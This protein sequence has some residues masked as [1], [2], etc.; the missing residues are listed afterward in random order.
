MASV[1]S[2]SPSAQ[3]HRRT[4]SNEDSDSWQ[5]IGSN[6]G[7]NPASVFSPSP[8][9]GAG[10]M[11][12]WVIPRYPNHVER[13]P[14]GMSPLDL[15]TESQTA[16]S[17]SFPDQTAT[18]LKPNAGGLNT[19]FIGSV[20]GGTE[21]FA[22]DPDF[23]FQEPF[24]NTFDLSEYYNP[25]DDFDASSITGLE[26]FDIPTQ[27]AD[28]SVPAHYRSSED[29]ALPWNAANLRKDEQ[30]FEFIS[31]DA[32]QHS[33]SNSGR[34]SSSPVSPGIKFEKAP[35]P[36]RKIQ[37]KNNKIEKKKAEPASRFVI[38]TPTIINASAGKPNPYEC[39][40]AMRP[41]HKGRKG[42]LANET[43]ESALQCDTQRP[44]KN[45]TK[46]TAAV[47]Q[48]MCWQFQ[49]FLPVLFPDFIR[50]H[51][52]KDQM[53]SFFSQHIE[54]FTIG[55]VEQSCE[56]ELF[57]G[58]RFDSTLTVRANF[59][60]AKTNEVLQ[61]WHM[62]IGMNQ[63]DLQTRD[64]APIGIDLDNAPYR[65]DLRKKTRDYIQRITLEP[66]FA[67]QVTDSFRHT[68]LPCKV[69]KIVQRFSQRSDSSMVKKA[70]SIYAMHYVLTR[71]LCM[72][73]ASIH[74]LQGTNLIPR[75]VPWLT[76]RVL[77]RQVKSILDEQLL[78]EM[79]SLFDGFSKSLKPKSRKEWAPCLAAFL[80]LCLFMEAL[81]TAA[82][83][84]VAS[85]NEIN[86]RNQAK[87]G[88][89]QDFA[90]QIC[91]E[92]ENM[93]FKQFAYQFHQVYQTHTKDAATKAFN[94]LL[95]GSFAEQGEL[96]GPTHEMVLALRKLLQGDSYYELDFLVADPIL[97]NEGTHP[98]PR[99]VSLNYTGRLLARFLLSFEDDR[100]LFD[101]RY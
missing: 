21:Q 43:K 11:N 82:D 95:D 45:C 57:S 75:N 79:Q 84:F 99:D 37:G 66:Q 22:P 13:S 34:L 35:S 76:P 74:S 55:G 88:Y 19:Q 80:V 56:V 73:P 54:S 27:T 25:F 3:S 89:K 97:P 17:T 85:Q 44:C 4:E 46:L 67:E 30:A 81:E 36:L 6:V 93:P 41:S 8:V 53:A 32:S 1:A 23:L 47:P 49:D 65:D 101:G 15:N 60:T 100:Y 40:E 87:P 58:T 24:D 26:G 18:S 86:I 59:F 94:P 62:N 96:D 38:M 69:L 83:T 78:K 28:L 16:F 39:F 68:D 90:R 98:F 52:K 42:P 51:F 7:S 50:G 20:P 9:S 29:H 77:N 63:L 31:S 61:H 48:I 2:A 10:S 72:T 92:V 64:A 14:Q 71:H 5:Y 33:S 70:L 91:K 12:S